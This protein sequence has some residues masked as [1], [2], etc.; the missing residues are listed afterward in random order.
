LT[1]VYLEDSWVLE[2]APRV[3]GI[4]FRIE[5]VLTPEHALYGV[6]QPREQY[7][8]RSGWLDVRG[9]E[10]VDVRLSGAQPA[11]SADGSRDLGNIDR[12]AFNLADNVWEM[13]GEWGTARFREPVVELVLD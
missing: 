13:E 6:P 7:C 9:A 11:I 12:F 10:P 1:S 2:V 3:D 4:A 8:Y 5:A